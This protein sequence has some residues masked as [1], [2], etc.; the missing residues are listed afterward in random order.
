MRRESTEAAQRLRVMLIYRRMI[1]SIRLCGHCQMEELDRLGLI[2]Y[3]AVQE[4]RLQR[5]DLAWADVYLLGRLDSWYEHQLVKALK[6]AGKYRMYILDDDLLNMPDYIDSARY[7]K[8]EKIQ[9]FI[10]DMLDMSDAILSPSRLLLEKYAAGG[11]TGVLT[12]EPA[13]DPVPFESHRNL[14]TVRIG[15]AGSNDRIADVEQF[16]GDALKRIHEAYGGKTEF[17]FFGSAPAFA[18]E[19]Q[20]RCVPYQDSYAEYRN[21]LNGLALDIGLAPMPDTPFHHCK[22]YNKFVEYAAAGMTGIFSDC[23]PYTLI[24]DR[25]QY[26]RFC[27]NTSEAWYQALRAEIDDTA[28]REAHRRACSK[29]AWEKMSVNAAAL[30]LYEEM[31]KLDVRRESAAVDIPSMTVLKIRNILYRGTEYLSRNGLRAPRLILRKLL[32]KFPQTYRKQDG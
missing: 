18:E 15:F 30:A 27:E 21:I 17:V 5:E 20:A 23:A 7:Y 24:P 14:E 9:A 31:K 25:E 32:R 4:M 26:G 19:L 6:R 8:Q 2:E 13:I 29:C 3:R 22:H 10:R 16:L 1:P 12:E 11:K 28:G